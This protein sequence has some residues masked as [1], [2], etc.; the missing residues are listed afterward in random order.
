MKSN[1]RRTELSRRV[2]SKENGNIEE[3]R[4]ER[5]G[6]IEKSRTKIGRKRKGK[7]NEKGELS[8]EVERKEN[9]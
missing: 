5:N 6:N 3:N 7:S 2:E 9:E 8:K 4:A 1:R